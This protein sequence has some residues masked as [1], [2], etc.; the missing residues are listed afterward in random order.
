[1]AQVLSV[2]EVLDSMTANRV[3]SKGEVIP[4]R[5]NKK[6]FTKLLKAMMND[7]TLTAQVAK[8]SEGSLSKVEDIA[9]GE[10][11]RKWCR[12]LVEKA[13]IDPAESA[14][15]LSSDFTIDNA[16]GFYEF[17]ATAIWL[18]ME[19]GNMFQFIPK[20]DFNA[21]S[22][23]VKKVGKKTKSYHA[24]DIRTGQDLGEFE[25]EY[26]EHRVL[27]VTKAG[28]P[29]WLQKRKKLK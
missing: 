24:K 26:D 28:C 4:N 1:M 20:S 23:G 17:I 7:P 18:Y 5:F 2:D 10:S 16:E 9:V 15:V 27:Y 6:E 14:T 3:N 8:V 29:K 11:F 12:S 25:T 19:R 21:A 13:G 22:I